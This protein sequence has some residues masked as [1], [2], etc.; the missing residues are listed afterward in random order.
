MLLESSKS[1]WEKLS[2]ETSIWQL[3]TAATQGKFYPCE[4]LLMQVFSL[5]DEILA[6]ISLSSLMWNWAWSFWVEIL[7]INQTNQEFLE[8]LYF[9]SDKS[10][11][12]T[13]WCENSSTWPHKYIVL[14]L[15]HGHIPAPC[16]MHETEFRYTAWASWFLPERFWQKR[17][18]WVKKRCR[19]CAMQ[20]TVRPQHYSLHLCHNI[21]II[22]SQIT[23]STVC[24]T[25]H[26]GQQQ[27]YHQS[28]AVCIT[29]PLWGESNSPLHP[30]P[31]HR[32]S[33]G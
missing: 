26:P 10:Y 28:S 1:D 8:D 20:S 22:E 15:N 27:R 14:H 4:L 24:S 19:S 11:L 18:T 17:R 33:I 25:A 6:V 21:S 7:I 23:N 12:L 16:I 9:G 13:S 2:L 29:D 32:V 3:W 31:T 5:A 30:N